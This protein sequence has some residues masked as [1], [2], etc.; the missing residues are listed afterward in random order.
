MHRL[1]WVG[2]TAATATLG[3]EGLVCEEVDL[4]L[5]KVWQYDREKG[6][7]D[8]RVEPDHQILVNLVDELCRKARIHGTCPVV[9]LF[10]L[11]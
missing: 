5:L 1:V 3:E 4:Q 9:K 7:P 10:A 2:P 11:L 8:H 6:I